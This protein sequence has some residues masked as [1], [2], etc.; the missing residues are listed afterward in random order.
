MISHQPVRDRYKQ[1]NIC[2]SCKE[3]KYK[4]VWYAPDSKLALMI[5]T[6]KDFFSRHVCPACQMQKKGLCEGVLYVKDIPKE[7]YDQV[8]S[9]IFQEAVS[10]YEKTHSIDF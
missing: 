1:M 10:D 4:G 3:V 9:T 6:K 8:I 5:D 2:P 7:L